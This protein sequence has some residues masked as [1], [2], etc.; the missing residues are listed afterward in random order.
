MADRAG[1]ILICAYAFP[2]MSGPAERRWAYLATE[3][4]N[5]GWHVDV[6]TVRPSRT[7]QPR[8]D[9]FLETIGRDVSVYRTYP[10]PF[11]GHLNTGLTDVG[12]TGSSSI[13]RQIRKLLRFLYRATMRRSVI[14]DRMVVWVPFAFMRL[15]RLRTHGRYDVVISASSPLTSH[16]VGYIASRMSKA[17]WVSDWSDPISFSP[18]LDMSVF[19]KWACAKLERGLLRRMDWALFG[20]EATRHEFAKH[21]SS[22]LHSRSSILPPGHAP[23]SVPAKSSV[24]DRQF[25]LVHTGMFLGAARSPLNLLDSLPL[26]QDLPIELQLAGPIPDGLPVALAERGLDSTV[27]TLGSISFE[28]ALLL[29]AEASVLVVVGNAGHLQL[30][31]KTVDYIAARRPILVIRSHP[32]DVAAELV[33]QYR[34]GIIV[35]DDPEQI[36]AAIRDLYKLWSSGRL[37]EEFDLTEVDDFLWPSLAGRINQIL[38]ELVPGYG[39]SGFRT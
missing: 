28:N 6:L 23:R 30:P 21:Y 5:L 34:R 10:G 26:L 2:P 8:D 33:G 15:M 12:P 37:E 11:H 18:T 1:S 39:L 16:V 27:R 29:Q 25:V 17:V 31:S 14:P 36:A 19:Q 24:G 4:S 35:D 7:Y 22:S 9:S 32:G 38:T 3:L 20:T 13:R